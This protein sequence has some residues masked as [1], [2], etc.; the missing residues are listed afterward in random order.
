[1][2]ALCLLLVSSGCPHPLPTTHEDSHE[3]AL[4]RDRTGSWPD[5]APLGIT[6]QFGGRGTRPS[7]EHGPSGLVATSGFRRR[8]AEAQILTA[9]AGAPAWYPRLPLAPGAL[10]PC[11]PRGLSTWGAGEGAG[12]GRGSALPA[13]GGWA[14]SAPRELGSG[15]GR[16]RPCPLGRAPPWGAQRGVLGQW[17]DERLQRSV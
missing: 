15:A 14:S 4:R 2:R 6:G 9:M 10:D 5:T 8:Q 16:A 17:G 1:M 12:E 13:A 7:S 11:G 3:R